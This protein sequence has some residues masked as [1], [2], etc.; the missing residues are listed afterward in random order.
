MLGY[1]VSSNGLTSA[2]LRPGAVKCLPEADNT[3]KDLSPGVSI[4]AERQHNNRWFMHQA[5]LSL[6]STKKKKKSWNICSVML[7]SYR[8][9]TG[10][11]FEGWQE[12]VPVNHHCFFV[13]FINPTI[14]SHLDT[15]QSSTHSL[16]ISLNQ[17][18][19]WPECLLSLCKLDHASENLGFIH[20]YSGW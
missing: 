13:F 7:T 15:F 20:F 14:T 12:V 19:C 18:C 5:S 11:V 16:V 2:C 10:S 6:L 4:K 1:C 8:H 17:C 3:S 9:I